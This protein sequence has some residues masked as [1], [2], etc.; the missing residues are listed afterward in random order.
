M[1][2]NAKWRNTHRFIHANSTISR[3]VWPNALKGNWAQEQRTHTA[4]EN[5][6]VRRHWKE[7]PAYET[8]EWV[9]REAIKAVWRGDALKVIKFVILVGWREVAQQFSGAREV[10]NIDEREASW[11]KEAGVNSISEVQTTRRAHV[12]EE[13]EWGG[14]FPKA[15][16]T[17]TVAWTRF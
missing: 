1:D 13:I 17:C 4:K 5:G 15:E 10:W 2:S 12:V 7:D 9:E 11:R 3:K 14:V 16:T 8:W 6:P